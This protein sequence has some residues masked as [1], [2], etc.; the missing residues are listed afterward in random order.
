MTDPNIDVESLLAEFGQGIEQPS[1][2]PKYG[3]QDG[4]MAIFACDQRSEAET[5]PVG[6]IAVVV[7]IDFTAFKNSMR[8]AIATAYRVPRNLLR[9]DSS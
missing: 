9:T 6:L 4:S 5:Q 3:E 7:D 1:D 8:R 2:E